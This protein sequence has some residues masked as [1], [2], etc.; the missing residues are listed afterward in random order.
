MV[1]CELAEDFA[2][3]GHS[4]TLLDREVAPLAG[5]LPELASATIS[6]SAG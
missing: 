2:R 6:S 3:A 4:V 5:L 1:G